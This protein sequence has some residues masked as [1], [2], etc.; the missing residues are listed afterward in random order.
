MFA[1]AALPSRFHGAAFRSLLLAAINAN[2]AEKTAKFAAGFSKLLPD[3]SCSMT[4][5]EERDSEPLPPSGA[6][7]LGRLL[8]VE[9]LTEWLAALEG[10]GP[11]GETLQ[12]RC[13]VHA[14][15]HFR[16]V[17]RALSKALSSSLPVED[18]ATVRQQA[19]QRLARCPEPLRT[20]L[21]LRR[22][23]EGASPQSDALGCVDLRSGLLAAA[24]QGRPRAALRYLRRLMGPLQ[25]LREEQSTAG[26]LD[27]ISLIFL[28]CERGGESSLAEQWLQR[29]RAAGHAPTAE[30][31]WYSMKAFAKK[32]LSRDAERCFREM[33]RCRLQATEME[34]TMMI[35]ASGKL[36]DSQRALAWLTRMHAVQLTVDVFAYNAVLGA[37]SME[38]DFR[39]ALNL[40][41]AMES[42]IL[43]SIRPDAASYAAAA[44]ACTSSESRRRHHLAD[45]AEQLVERSRSAM[46]EVD[47][48]VYRR[49]LR[50]SARQ[51][52]AERVG[53]LLSRMA[54]L[55]TDPGP[56][57][58][59]EAL[60]ACSTAPFLGSAGNLLEKHPRGALLLARPFVELGDWR[61]VQRLGRDTE[62]ATA[63]QGDTVSVWPMLRLMALAE[64]V[65]RKRQKCLEAAADFLLAG[66]QLSAKDD[67]P[68]SAA[69]VLLR[70]GLGG[71]AVS[72]RH[73]N[74]A[75]HSPLRSFRQSHLGCASRVS[76]ALDAEDPK[77]AEVWLRRWMQIVACL[78]RLTE[79]S[80][81][82]STGP[83]RRRIVSWRDHEVSPL[84]RRQEDVRR[85]MQDRGNTGKPSPQQRYRESAEERGLA[86]AARLAAAVAAATSH[87]PAP[88][89]QA[90]ASAEN[91]RL[92]RHST[93][94]RTAPGQPTP[95]VRQAWT[96]DRQDAKERPREG[97]Q[98]EMRA[99]ETRQPRVAPGEVAP[100]VDTSPLRPRLARAQSARRPTRPSAPA[101]ARSADP[102]RRQEGAFGG[103]V[104]ERREEADPSLLE[105]L[106]KAEKPRPSGP[107]GIPSPRLHGAQAAGAR[108]STGQILTAT[109]A[110][111]ASRRASTG[112]MS[113]MDQQPTPFRS[114]SSKIFSG[115]YSVAKFLGR[116]ASASVW[117]AV[118]SDNEQR[119]AVKVFDQGQR[120][121]RQAH[122]EMKV[123]SRVRHP[124]IVEAFEVIETP[125]YAQLVCEA[126]AFDDFG[127]Q[128]LEAVR[129]SVSE[130]TSVV[131]ASAAEGVKR[132]REKIGRPAN[133]IEFEAQL[134][135]RAKSTR[136]LAGIVEMH[137]SWV[138]SISAGNKEG[139]RVVSGD[140]ELGFK[141][142][143]LQSRALEYSMEVIV[144]EPSLRE[145]YVDPPNPDDKTSA[146][147][148]L[149]E[150][151][152]KT[153]AFPASQWQG[154][155][156][157]A[158]TE[159]LPR[160][161]QATW[162]TTAITA[163][164]ADWC[165]VASTSFATRQGNSWATPG[166]LQGCLSMSLPQR[167]LAHRQAETGKGRPG[168]R[169]TNGPVFGGL[170]VRKAC[171][172]FIFLVL[173]TMG[174]ILF[175]WV[176]RGNSGSFPFSVPALVFNA[177][178]I[179]AFV[180]FCWAVT[181]GSKSVQL[182]WRPDMV[183]RFF[184]TTS[185]FV[186]GDM[187]SF[188]SIEHLD[189]GT[190]SL[191]G[192]ALAIIL[193]V[194]LSRLV[195]K[196][197]QSLQ[198]YSLV[199][200][201]AVATMFFCQSEVQARQATNLA[202][203][204]RSPTQASMSWY[205]GL[206][207]RSTA[208]FLTSF[209]AVLQE[210][211]LTNRPGIPFMVQQSWMSLAAMT[212]SLLTLRFVH[213]LPFSALT[214][215]FGHWR[216]LVLL[217]SYVASGL[218][219]A[220]MVK[221]LG[222]IAKSL[223][224]PIYL[225]FCYAYAVYT[226]SASL[227]LQVLAAWTA[228]TACILLYAI[229]K[230]K[231]PQSEVLNERAKRAEQPTPSAASPMDPSPESTSLERQRSEDPANTCETAF[232]RGV[233][234]PL[235]PSSAE[236]VNDTDAS[237]D[238]SESKRESEEVLYTERKEL[239]L[240]AEFLKQELKQLEATDA[241]EATKKR[242]DT[243]AQLLRTYD[244]VRQNLQT[245]QAQRDE[246][247]HLREQELLALQQQ[248]QA[249]MVGLQSFAD[250]CT[251]QQRDL[252][253]ELNQSQDSIKLQLQHM[254][255]VRAGIDKE[256]DELDERKRQ[257]RIELD[258][259][260]RQLDEARMKQKQ[261]MESCD[262]QRAEFYHTKAALK[263]KLDAANTDGAAK[264]KEKELLDQTRQLIEETSVALQA[265]VR[266]QTEELK[267]KQ[268]EFQSH[269]K[270]LLLDHLRYAEGRAKDL[271]A[272]A[273]KAV[274]S[275]DPGAKE[276]ARAA[277]QGAAD[278]LDE[279]CKD[280]DFLGDSSVK[281]QLENLRVAHSATLALLGAPASAAS[282]PA[283]ATASSAAAEAPYPSQSAAQ[284]SQQVPII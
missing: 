148:C 145:Q 263:E 156:R 57:A 179:D 64:A 114:L 113:I 100:R 140:H 91:F 77:Q 58:I 72:H 61:R 269:F 232:G 278:A 70:R 170:L 59:L 206:A 182:L 62:T 238:G 108:R 84:M 154:L 87:H 191:V 283:T 275:Q 80:T 159:G 150:L 226:G 133:A 178:A 249:R 204:L 282:A 74:A 214:E 22:L 219:T 121:K 39:S 49:L 33:L 15:R 195:L 243:S 120:D 190:F 20:E 124:R 52:D 273:Q 180:G 261:H 184:I 153:L 240:R 11:L 118:R 176:K 137:K 149:Y 29:I 82:D 90:H 213:G 251:S 271:Q 244:A 196:K 102:R 231:A 27:Q 136:T 164:K 135:S 155:I 218:T 274:A 106:A 183:W 168:C 146:I 17:E 54:A 188:M 127:F 279:L 211:L 229:S 152:S 48:A 81:A 230:I 24:R 3:G 98:P 38:G 277:A 175:D 68:C 167:P 252:E 7:V 45:L 8:Q 221:K 5:Q 281:A 181:Q 86:A 254:D 75:G 94:C 92:R 69:A 205:L 203:V 237:A 194:L 250:S 42:G 131:V 46:M 157:V 78:P 60:S 126:E 284:S 202:K 55:C 172:C 119:V 166:R 247:R 47:G 132:A 141:E 9:D 51:G 30:H 222:A 37:Y 105:D 267:Q 103:F 21:W 210:Q 208:V 212:L 97:P 227:T 4:T 31:F 26:L 207:E 160:E 248:I 107:V 187:L 163:M 109:V 115:S 95:S 76:A 266:E 177:W 112:S 200:A 32:G 234:L 130:R 199:A 117:E 99:R 110:A 223:C 101:R 88:A 144:S 216:V 14:S 242:I 25:A 189:V 67:N 268:A 272:E 165:L 161:E 125:R 280:I 245:S 270:L 43:H 209:A 116:G 233:A 217:F 260:S 10:G 236:T 235:T 151:F 66:G 258:T 169:Q 185:L 197:G 192:K 224:V 171:L 122:R 253:G 85:S 63:M 173:S 104:P 6:E 215:G 259:V 264:A 13:A 53:R 142:M 246:V 41:K 220:L 265:T 225:G 123:L 257:L 139:P 193:T 79:V 201:V 128:M 134:E 35:R 1:A 158:M 89:V 198:Q 71:R 16:E 56:S 256:I 34:C 73:R 241:E 162:L 276:A 186:A 228:S 147:A 23:E 36:G 50:H 83:R 262:R 19:L 111:V 96:D 44:N 12:H 93:G 65:P 2:D 28:A 255:E 143:F 18:A 129:H 138:Q 174:P 239:A 40:V